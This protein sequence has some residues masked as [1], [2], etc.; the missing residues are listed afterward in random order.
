MF[1]TLIDLSLDQ[2]KLNLDGKQ[3]ILSK[4]NGIMFFTRIY[5]CLVYQQQ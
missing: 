4:M 5:L 1:M 3:E 2:F